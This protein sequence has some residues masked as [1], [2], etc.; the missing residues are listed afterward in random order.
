MDGGLDKALQISRTEQLRVY[1]LASTEQYRHRGL[2]RSFKRLSAHDERVCPACIAADV[3]EYDVMTD[4]DEH[5][6]GR[7]TMVP[8]V[9]GMPEPKWTSGEAWLKT[10]DEATQ[11]KVLGKTR[12]GLWQSGKVR[13]EDF[14]E[15]EGNRTWGDSRKVVPIEDLTG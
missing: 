4:L 10:Q 12:L 11:R 15:R 7:C 9:K 8:V 2:V 5:I 6:M 1:R 3:Q 13:F 14:G